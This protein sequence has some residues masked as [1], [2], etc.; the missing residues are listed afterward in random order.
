METYPEIV[1][2]IRM[3]RTQVLDL[4][5][6]SLEN[7]SILQVVSTNL[8]DGWKLAKLDQNNDVETNFELRLVQPGDECEL[9]F[10]AGSPRD[11]EKLAMSVA[12]FLNAVFRE[13]IILGPDRQHLTDLP[14]PSESAAERIASHLSNRGARTIEEISRSLGMRQYTVAVNLQILLG[15]GIV[16]CTP[17]EVI[18]R[19]FFCK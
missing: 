11:S 8:L 12:A 16:G 19:L 18:P 4:I 17:P 6:S 14:G 7:S 13:C 2:G 9:H 5:K 15:K 10:T 3:H 1:F